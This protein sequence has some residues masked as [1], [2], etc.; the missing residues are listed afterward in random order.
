MELGKSPRV[1]K[2]WVRAVN[3]FHLGSFGRSSTLPTYDEARPAPRHQA[4]KPLDGFKGLEAGRLREFT[5]TVPFLTSNQEANIIENA[6]RDTE[7]G[8]RGPL[9]FETNIYLNRSK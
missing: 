5:C 8:K 1:L 9:S 2:L 3:S 6:M 7:A 4:S